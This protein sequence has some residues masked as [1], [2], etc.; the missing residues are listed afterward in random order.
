MP[1]LMGV[2][3]DGVESPTVTLSL[4]ASV[5]LQGRART[6]FQHLSRA[7]ALACALHDGIAHIYWAVGLRSP[8]LACAG[9]W[10]VGG[11]LCTAH[12]LCAPDSTATGQPA[13]ALRC[14]AQR[15][16]SRPHTACRAYTAA[17]SSK[18]LT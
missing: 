3:P 16:A 14:D 7:F 12:R 15:R 2:A 10:L 1:T 9:C 13:P 18:T 6:G 17:G 8:Q 11:Q 4:D 5:A